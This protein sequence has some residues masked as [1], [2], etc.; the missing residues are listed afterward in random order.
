MS[1]REAVLVSA[2]LLGRCCRYHGGDAAD[3]GLAPLLEGKR[4]VAIC[5]EEDGGLGTPRPPAEIDSAGGGSAVLDGSASVRVVESARDVTPAFLRG[6]EAALRQAREHGASVAYLKDRSPSCGCS[7]IH[8]A[9]RL[10]AGEGVTAALLRRRG[11][12]VRPRG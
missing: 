2:C 1:E 12:D 4:V 7:R 8:V 9:G 3:P 11:I 6:A 5:P 10:V